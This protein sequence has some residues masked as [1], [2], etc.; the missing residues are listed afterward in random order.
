MSVAVVV[1]A[2]VSIVTQFAIC[3]FSFNFIFRPVEIL[4]LTKPLQLAGVYAFLACNAIVFNL[5][6]NASF[7]HYA[8]GNMSLFN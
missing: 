3:S 1:A 5:Y 7:I 8:G 4:R 2:A 6:T